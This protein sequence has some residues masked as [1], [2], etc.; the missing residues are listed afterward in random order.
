MWLSGKLAVAR[1]LST[2]FDYPAFA[3]AQAALFGP[4]LENC[5][6][7]NRFYY[8]PTFLFFIY[9]FGTMP[10]GIALG[11][12]IIVSF[13][14]Y[15]ATV[16]TIIPW[17]AAVIIAI[18]PIFVMR[19]NIMM[20][21]NGFLT[22]VLIGMSLVLMQ[23]RPCLSGVF[24]ALL[25]YKPHFGVLLPIALLAS[26]NW[27]VIGSAGVATV[28]LGVLAGMAF[29]YEG[30]TAF[31]DSLTDRSSTLGPAAWVEP[32]LQS[33]FGLF[34]LSGAS[35]GIAWSAQVVAA[36]I[37]S[38]GI[39][40]LWSKPISHNLKAAAVC[41]GILL[42]SPYALFYDLTIPC[43]AAAFFI[44]EGLTRG[45]LPGERIIILICWIPLLFMAWRSGP[46]VCLT[47]LILVARR[48]VL[49]YGYSRTITDAIIGAV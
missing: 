18:C 15:L 35:K 29:G 28:A 5:P 32:R 49:Y 25:T 34:Q 4:V 9:P 13:S 47:I 20:G 45:F 39:W 17:R 27:R 48:I 8:P 26:R 22:A 12:W 10:Y 14:L 11:A 19:S 40:V 41:A 1:S 6:N 24:L 2:V 46:I 16:Y 44:K 37:V 43:I 31:I 42:V 30:W 23:R 38:L 33:V 21:H 36:T 7:F 3:D